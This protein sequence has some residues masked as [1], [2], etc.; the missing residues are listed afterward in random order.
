MQSE[1]EELI[2]YPMMLVELQLFEKVETESYRWL[3]SMAASCSRYSL[4]ILLHSPNSLHIGFY[5]RNPPF[6]GVSL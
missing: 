6:L 3:Q 2:D 5:K 4:Y 1:V